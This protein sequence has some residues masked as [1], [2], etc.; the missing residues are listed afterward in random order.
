M[1]ITQA[2]CQ[3]RQYAIKWQTQL[4]AWHILQGSM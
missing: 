3:Q 2:G 1:D 4:L